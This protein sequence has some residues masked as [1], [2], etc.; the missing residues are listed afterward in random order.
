[1]TVARVSV[2][3]DTVIGTLR[4]TP[5]GEGAHPSLEQDMLDPQHRPDP[6]E[7]RSIE[8]E[9]EKIGESVWETGPLDGLLKSWVHSVDA[10]G[11]YNA[12][13]ERPERSYRTPV[14]HLAPALILRARTERSY[15]RAFEDIIA[16]LNAGEPV[17]E[18]VSRFIS[19]SENQT[20]DDLTS[21]RGNGARPGET[22]FPLPA[23]DA[24]R[25]DP[26]T[27]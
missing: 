25:A 22:F 19:V 16:Q 11:E 23:N 27:D 18:G 15:I 6:Q 21:G 1:M 26:L 2:E 12:V 17:P 5:A 14:V 10:R 3:F 4:V 24:Q 20:R 8:E 13:L 9:L 7:L